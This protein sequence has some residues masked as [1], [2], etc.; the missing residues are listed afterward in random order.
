MKFSTRTGQTQDADSLQCNV[1]MM[2]DNCIIKTE[3]GVEYTFYVI[4]C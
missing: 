4:Y 3:Y 2:I 1:F